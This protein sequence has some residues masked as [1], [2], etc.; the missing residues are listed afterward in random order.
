MRE[1]E[2]ATVRAAAD[3]DLD[4]FEGLVRAFQEP[5]W[6]FLRGMVNDPALAEDLA[7]ETFLRVFSR[8]DTFA[9]R[10]RFSTWLFQIA[11]NLAVDALRSRERR[12]LLPLRIGPRSAPPGHELRGEVAEAVRSL[13]PKLREPLLL[14]EIMGFSC[15]ETAEILSIPEGTVKSRMF[16][17]RKALVAWFDADTDTD[18]QVRHEV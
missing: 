7:Q 9:Y 1:P 8:L 2:P 11:R 4:A 14:I 17:A 12:Q 10:S 13:S 5:V 18:G 16:H 3:G 15:R 6:R